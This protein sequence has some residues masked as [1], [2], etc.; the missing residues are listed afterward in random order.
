VLRLN[1]SLEAR[2]RER[3]AQLQESNRELEA[4]S[5]S[6]SHDLRAPLRSIEGFAKILLRD[7]TG[8]QLDA[9]AANYMHR[10]SDASRRMGNLIADLLTLS[11]LTRIEMSRKDVDLSEFARDILADCQSREPDRSVST[12]VQAGLVTDADPILMRVALENLL[13]NAWKYT[14][15]TD[16]AHIAFEA[17]V[18]QEELVFCIRDNGAGFD[19]AHSDQL[20]APFQRLH[21][22]DEF[23]GNGIGLATVQRVI[24]RHGGRIWAESKP[25]EGAVFYFTLGEA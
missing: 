19:M 22:S 3:T 18:Q 8:K 9:T 25:G 23:E 11:R 15:K 20:F 13:G 14:G 12:A 5:Y 4:F 10:M 6:V 24:R 2:V 17:G 7:Y 21:R 16:A 1:A